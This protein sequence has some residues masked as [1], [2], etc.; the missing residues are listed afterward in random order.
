MIRLRNRVHK[1]IDVDLRIILSD[2]IESDNA[3]SD[4]AQWLAAL[5]NPV[6]AGWEKFQSPTLKIQGRIKVQNS[7]SL[8]TSFDPGQGRILEPLNLDPSLILES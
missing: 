1:L 8:G 5:Q 3:E 4:S 7:K 6:W 2:S